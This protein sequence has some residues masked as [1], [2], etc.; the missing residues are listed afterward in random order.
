MTHERQRWWDS[1][2]G[3]E[4]Q[5]R[6]AIE[7]SKRKIKWAKEELPHAFGHYREAMK[8]GLRRNKFLIK[9]L[10][11]QIAMRPYVLKTTIGNF[12]K[13]PCCSVRLIKYFPHCACCGQKLRW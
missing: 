7:E 4:K 2:P 1:L 6:N 3:Y 9:A 13:C 12:D 5:A 11:K 10:R 8:D